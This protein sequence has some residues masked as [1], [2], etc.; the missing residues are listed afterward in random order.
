MDLFL[1][2]HPQSGTLT[3]NMWDEQNYAIMS[4]EWRHCLPYVITLLDTIR[5]Y[6]RKKLTWNQPSE[7][8]LLWVIA[9]LHRQHDGP[10]RRER[11]SDSRKDWMKDCH[12]QHNRDMEEKRLWFQSIHRDRAPWLQAAMVGSWMERD[13][14]PFNSKRHRKFL[15]PIGWREGGGVELN[16]MWHGVA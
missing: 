7:E 12:I 1:P 6:K 8:P 16:T 10:W 4:L 5:T 3:N 13:R 11:I 9:S 14:F 2:Q 15:I